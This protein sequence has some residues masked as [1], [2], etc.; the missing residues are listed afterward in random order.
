[1]QRDWNAPSIKGQRSRFDRSVNFKTT[2]DTDYLIPV[3]WDEILP[4]DSV[5]MS[6]SAFTRLATPIYPI[7]D[8][9]SME[10][11]W[12]Y[13][14]MRLV[15]ENTEQFF[16]EDLVGGDGN[17]PVKP[18][19]STNAIGGAQPGTLENYLGIPATIPNLEFDELPLRVYYEIWNEWFRSEVLQEKF[20]VDKGDLPNDWSLI[21][22]IENGAPVLKRNK[23]HDY[24][25]SSLPWPQRGPDIALP[26]VNPFLNQQELDPQLWIAQTNTNGTV[27]GL[28]A[29]AAS[30]NNNVSFPASET[31]AGPLVPAADGWNDNSGTINQL[32]FAFAVQ[33]Y[34]ER[35]AR[36]GTRY[37][38]LLQSHFGVTSPDARL[39]RPEYLGRNQTR[40]NVTPVATTFEN[41]GDTSTG[42]TVGDLGAM[43][44]AS[45]NGQN[46][47]VKSF[48][49]HGFIMGILNVSADI[50]YQ[51]GLDRRWH[52]ETR[53]E[54]YWPAFAGLG[55][56]AVET[57][58]IWAG[59]ATGPVGRQKV[60]SYQE[61]YAE[62]RYG[63]SLITGKFLSY[64][65]DTL[66]A[67]HLSQEFTQEPFLNEEFLQSNT[68]MDRV[69]AAPNEPHFIGDF[70]FH[71]TWAR[72]MPL[73]G[74]PGG[75]DRF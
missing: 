15:Y 31:F 51:Q 64:I 11:F 13:V 4:G 48:V 43:G 74:I 32:R 65:P 18:M 10:V 62:Y 52:R 60:F 1:M 41:T 25:T 68:P 2:F 9:M 66:D 39:Q 38:Q 23:K 22:G 46:S 8:N 3:Y 33:R 58:E 53:F 21:P 29:A 16:G 73:Y 49:E 7:M 59:D 6:M 75:I 56:Q 24:F 5:S 47:F 34:Y 70:F 67:W 42:R 50:T 14:P 36:A 26:V 40:I 12:F 54:Y 72:A 57:Q 35:D 30:G 27:G 37:P 69:L 61:R 20:P 44:T 63:K 71:T 28:S 55:E 19:R 45:V 17:A